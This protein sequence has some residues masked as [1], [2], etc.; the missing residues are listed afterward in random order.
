MN[1]KCILATQ[2]PRKDG[3]VVVKINR[4]SEYAHRRAYFLSKGEIPK[5]LTIDHLCSVRNCVNPDHLEAVSIQD[6]IKRRPV[7]YL[8]GNSNAK[9]RTYCSKGHLLTETAWYRSSG[10]RQCRTCK[11][12]SNKL[13]R[14]RVL[15]GAV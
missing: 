4:K 5:G 1:S 14:S 2:K 15:Q 6:N 7:D 12:E 8:M 11:N 13:Y 3:Y 10:K 9:P